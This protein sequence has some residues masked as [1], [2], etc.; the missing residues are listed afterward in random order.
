MVGFAGVARASRRESVQVA[1]A[2]LKLTLYNGKNFL[3][4]ASARL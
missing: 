4:A 3:P 2:T 1:R